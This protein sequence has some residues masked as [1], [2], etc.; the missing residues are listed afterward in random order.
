[1]Q[2]MISEGEAVLKKVAQVER[3]V[4]ARLSRGNAAGVCH[5]G[6]DPLNALS[7]AQDM[8]RVVSEELASQN[9]KLAL[10]RQRDVEF[11]AESPR[12]Y[13]VTDDNGVIRKANYA[14]AALLRRTSNSLQNNCLWVYVTQGARREFLRRFGLYAAGIRESGEWMTML[15]PRVGDAIHVWLYPSETGDGSG[16]EKRII[17][18]LVARD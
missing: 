15:A 8:L 1:M 3:A 16:R 6:H 12:A 7:V 17:W 10:V 11:F 13:V 14:A 2:G 9:E 4:Q 5:R 18:A